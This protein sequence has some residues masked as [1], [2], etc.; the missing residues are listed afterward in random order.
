[1]GVFEKDTPSGSF[2]TSTEARS[3]YLLASIMAGSISMTSI[4]FTVSNVASALAE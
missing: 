4:S 1:V 3:K 2:S